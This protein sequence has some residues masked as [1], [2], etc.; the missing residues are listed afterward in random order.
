MGQMCTNPLQYLIEH[1]GGD[2]AKMIA[3]DK[4]K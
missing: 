4:A 3:A 2:V 1:Y